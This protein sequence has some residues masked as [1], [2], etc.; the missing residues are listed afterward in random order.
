MFFNGGVLDENQKRVRTHPRRPRTR[1]MSVLRSSISRPG[2]MSVIGE[3]KRVAMR[4]RKWEKTPVKY[5]KP[6]ISCEEVRA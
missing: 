5:P 3:T 1:T 4:N 2:R 6:E